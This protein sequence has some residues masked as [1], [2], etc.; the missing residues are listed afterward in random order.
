M[1][2]PPWFTNG[3]AE[4]PFSRFC[5]G[6]SNSTPAYACAAT[7]GKGS[8]TAYKCRTRGDAGTCKRPPG[9]LCIYTRLCKCVEGCR[10]ISLT[11]LFGPGSL[12]VPS[13]PRTHADTSLRLSSADFPEDGY[14]SHTV[15]VPFPGTPVAPSASAPPS[16][17]A[18]PLPVVRHV[19]RRKV[20][21]GLVGLTGV[22]LVTVLGAERL[23]NPLFQ[24]GTSILPQ[25]PKAEAIATP[26]ISATAMA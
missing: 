5:H 7:A 22:G 20:I 9:A 25:K 8:L 2:S 1:R 4:A 18:E 3:Y 6:D 19:S 17:I 11:S 21:A 15:A 16:Q 24:S 26:N 12:S 23:L 14:I 10:C 13:L